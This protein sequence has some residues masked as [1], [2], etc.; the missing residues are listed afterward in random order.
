MT[1]TKRVNVSKRSDQF[2][3]K[4][5]LIFA[6]L[7]IDC[8]VFTFSSSG[9]CELYKTV[10]GSPIHPAQGMTLG[11]PNTN[12]MT[13]SSGSGMSVPLPSYIRSGHLADSTHLQDITASLAVMCFRPMGIR[14][15]KS[16]KQLF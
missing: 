9:L 15:Q 8:T 6:P 4:F 1:A 7:D 10:T 11:V 2:R 14:V 3:V 16:R 13:H 5:K 12:C